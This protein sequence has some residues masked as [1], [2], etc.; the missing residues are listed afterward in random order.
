MK[1]TKLLSSIIINSLLATGSLFA[2][3]NITTV[4]DTD[5]LTATLWNNLVSKI[6]ENGNKLEP[7]TNN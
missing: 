1:H 4:S 2:W 5:P 7:I 6:N 3:T